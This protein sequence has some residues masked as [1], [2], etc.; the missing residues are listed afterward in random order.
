MEEERIKA[1]K[2]WPEPQSIW[3]IQVFLSFA[4]FYKQFIKDFNKIATL[5]ILILKTTAPSISARPAYIKA[6]ENEHGTDGGDGVGGG[7]IDDK[8]VICQTL[9]RR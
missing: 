6:D 4:N 1:V 5:L 3:D 8:M 9:Q 7:R 2:A